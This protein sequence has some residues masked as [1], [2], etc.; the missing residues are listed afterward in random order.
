MTTRLEFDNL[1]KV[2]SLFVS[3]REAVIAYVSIIVVTAP[4]NKVFAAAGI[5]EHIL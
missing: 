3:I 1:E 4:P 2:F 5:Y